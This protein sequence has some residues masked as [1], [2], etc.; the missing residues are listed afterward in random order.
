MCETSW[1]DRPGRTRLPGRLDDLTR[2]P[3]MS[4]LA[5]CRQCF[6]SL[7]LG[8]FADRRYLRG[9]R[10]VISS[11]IAAEAIRQLYLEIRQD[12]V[13]QQQFFE[14]VRVA[15]GHALLM[16]CADAVCHLPCTASGPASGST[17][18]APQ[19]RTLAGLPWLGSQA[20]VLR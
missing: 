19:R 11:N 6:N 8:R 15:H 2:A 18:C 4:H 13:R 1:H 9:Q 17:C 12:N 10:L 7:R 20:A 5:V 14:D 3:D 16:I